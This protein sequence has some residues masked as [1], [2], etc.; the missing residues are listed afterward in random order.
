MEPV[1]ARGMVRAAI[2]AR[3]CLASSVMPWVPWVVLPASACVFAALETAPG[4]TPE[5]P[6]PRFPWPLSPPELAPDLL[7]GRRSMAG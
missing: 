2:R 5:L 7:R 1:R 3:A 4:L 6:P